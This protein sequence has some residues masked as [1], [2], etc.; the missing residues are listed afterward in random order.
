MKKERRNILVGLAFLSPNILGVIM[1]VIFPVG[2]SLVMAFT[3][4]DLTQFNMFKEKPRLNFVGF[5]NFKELIVGDKFVR[6]LGN[7][8][9]FM[10]G[11]P[12][13]VA[14]SLV[15]AILLS[16]DTR[17]GGGKPFLF[18]IAGAVLVVS[19][20]MLTVTGMGSSAMMILLV[21]AGCG[22]LMF[23]VFGGRTFY[24]T[25]FYTPHFVAGIATFILWKRLYNKDQGPIN[26]FL[27]PVL[28]QVTDAVTATSPVLYSVMFWV[29]LLLMAGVFFYGASRLR[30][31]MVDGDLGPRA[32]I[33]PGFLLILPLIVGGMWQFTKGTPIVTTPSEY[34]PTIQIP[35]IGVAT[36]WFIVLGLAV[37]GYQAFRYATARDKFPCKPFDGFGSA[38][39]LALLVMVAEFVLLGLSPVVGNLHA[40]A[41]TGDGLTA[42]SWL[43]D[44]PF[45]KPALMI[46]GFWA[47]IGSNSMLL[48]LAALSNVPQELYEAADIDGASP[49]QRF[50]NVT[51]PQLAPT[52]FFILVMAT[53]GGLQGGFEMARVMTQGG[54]A[55]ATTT[56]SYFIYQ[57]GFET[58]RL[59]FASAVAWALFVLIFSV[60]VFN[61]KFGNR[62][63]N[64]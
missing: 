26:N 49:L 40:M 39:V 47:A 53:I 44:A 54:P 41:T 24:R 38:F 58:G 10:M 51:W 28:N 13:S 32:A 62:Y 4:W 25:M 48:Y 15:A 9:F 3:D 46:M 31:M 20:V 19:I 18:L 33:L 21:G 37:V 11:I 61:W 36:I 45:A 5:G 55:G 43:R 16:K 12:F 7:T 8:L 17:G 6:F 14:G 57:E 27:Q 22:I 23:G 59:G 52:T 64:D 1:F 34:D 60:T 29:G 30:K 35:I 2:F 42:P 50:W 63:V 56:L